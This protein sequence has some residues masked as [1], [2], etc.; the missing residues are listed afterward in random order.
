[1]PFYEIHG[2]NEFAE[3]WVTQ[4]EADS[5]EEACEIAIQDA[6]EGEVSFI[7]QDPIDTIVDSVDTLED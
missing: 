3:F 1:M 2:H 6:I 5:P 4:V 7:A